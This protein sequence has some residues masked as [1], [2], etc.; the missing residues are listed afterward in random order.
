MSA[1]KGFLAAAGDE[2]NINW[3]T[4]R[5]IARERGIEVNE[6]K[7][8]KARNFSSLLLVETELP[9][10]RRRSVAGRSS[11]DRC[12]A[13][14]PSTTS[15]WNWPPPRTSLVMRYPDRPGMVGIFGTI[16]GRHGV[17]IAGMAVGRRS[18]AGEAMVAL[19][20]RRSRAACCAGGESAPRPSRW[21]R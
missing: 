5:W 14:W 1:L 4:P 9:D 20:P 8:S 11:T 18:R 19:T 13:S 15:T 10:G 7:S 6:E 2:A 21:R 12:R 16:L 3:S 17:N